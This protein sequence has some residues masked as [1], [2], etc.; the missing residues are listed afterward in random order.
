MR[1]EFEGRLFK[2]ALKIDPKIKKNG[3]FFE[4]RFL[5]DF[6]R[7]L[8]RFWEPKNLDFRIFFDD[9]SKHFSKWIS[10]GEKVGQKIEKCKLFRFLGP[11][12]RWSPASWEGL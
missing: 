6:G 10:D 12:L 5:F 1:S 7:V 11:R 3:S 9:F 2:K 8:G 4:P